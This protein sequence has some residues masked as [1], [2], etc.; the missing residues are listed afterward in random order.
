MTSH[1]LIYHY[2]E[3]TPEGLWISIP[4]ECPSG[5]HGERLMRQGVLGGYVSSPRCAVSNSGFF[6]GLNA[7]GA[8]M[9]RQEAFELGLI[10]AHH[11]TA[12]EC[13]N[14]RLV[15]EV[16]F[17]G[18]AQY[19]T[20]IRACDVKLSSRLGKSEI[21]VLAKVRKLDGESIPDVARALLFGSAF[22]G[23]KK[24]ELAALV[25]LVRRGVLKIYRAFAGDG[26]VLRFHIEE[27]VDN[28]R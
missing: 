23:M 2:R 4:H 25:K 16:R 14:D 8:E 1:S 6:F 21:D 19:D 18:Y 26:Y 24:G 28:G 12:G 7:K 9:D 22:K 17:C 10:E 15:T 11:L 20:A 27:G 13:F 3:L 5:A